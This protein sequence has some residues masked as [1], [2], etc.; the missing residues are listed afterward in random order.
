MSRRDDRVSMRQM[1]DHAAEAME[2][3]KERSRAELDQDRLLNLAI[4]RLLE[5]VGEAAGRVS[6]SGRLAHPEI[7]W[8]SIIGMRHR[9]AHGYDQIN[10]DIVW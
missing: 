8:A 6:E 3:L 7:A 5:I 2:A 4:V 9:L 1:L 10:L